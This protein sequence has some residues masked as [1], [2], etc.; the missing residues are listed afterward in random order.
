[1]RTGDPSSGYAP[2]LSVYI[3]A[4]SLYRRQDPITSVWGQNNTS[5]ERKSFFVF[6]FSFFLPLLVKR[7]ENGHQSG[8]RYLFIYLFY[9]L[10]IMFRYRMRNLCPRPK[11]KFHFCIEFGRMRQNLLTT[12][13]LYWNC[14]KFVQHR[15]FQ[16]TKTKRKL[17]L[18]YCCTNV[19]I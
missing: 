6:F 3:L 7:P 18:R 17:R 12:D 13:G 9:F 11:C 16:T 1:M 14:C 19:D 8:F 2:S 15:S 10:T 4:F 5:N